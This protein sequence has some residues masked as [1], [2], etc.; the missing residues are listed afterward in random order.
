MKEPDWSLP[1]MEKFSEEQIRHLKRAIENRNIVESIHCLGWALWPTDNRG[2]YDSGFLRTIADFLDIQN[3]PF[4]D[5][6]DKACEE[7]AQNDG[8]SVTDFNYFVD[9]DEGFPDGG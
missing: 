4:W 7:A 6:Y 5:E 1:G 3:K 2:Y 9:F 8:E